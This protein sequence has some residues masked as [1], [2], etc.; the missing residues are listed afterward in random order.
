MKEILRMLEEDARLT[1]EQIAVMT[2]KDTGDI[3]RAIE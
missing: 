1:P 3:R 2:E